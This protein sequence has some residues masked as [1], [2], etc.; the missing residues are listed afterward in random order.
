VEAGE[1]A[2]RRR[3]ACDLR[4]ASRCEAAKNAFAISG[5]SLVDALLE[6]SSTNHLRVPIIGGGQADKLHKVTGKP[7][8]AGLGQGCSACGE[9]LRTTRQP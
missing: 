6:N 3:Q 2:I 4:C 8:L 9:N 7:R 1:E 5:V